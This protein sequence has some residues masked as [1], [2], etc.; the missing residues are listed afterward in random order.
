MVQTKQGL[1]VTDPAAY[2]E[3]SFALLGDRDPI[4]VMEETAGILG[5]IVTQHTSDLL[6][7]RPFP[8]KWT[9]NEV[10]GHLGDAEW[11]LGFRVRVILAEEKPAILGMDQN[12][13][14]TAQRHNDRNPRDLVEMFR[15][16]RLFNLPIWK[17]LTPD[18]LQRVGMHDERGPESL[19]TMLRM[20]AAHDLHHIDQIN[21]YLEAAK[22]KG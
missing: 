3:K 18:D 22:E 14:V 5:G 9:P 4:P 16:L 17:Q 2:R 19:D 10:I 11:A 12:L 20:Y 13:W 8:G 7:A 15:G 6:R 1:E 21:R